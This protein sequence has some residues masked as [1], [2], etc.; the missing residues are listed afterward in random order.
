VGMKETFNLKVCIK[1]AAIMRTMRAHTR[2]GKNKKCSNCRYN[3]L[4]QTKH[5][6]AAHDF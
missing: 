6:L 1:R 2:R 4:S 5:T 3:F